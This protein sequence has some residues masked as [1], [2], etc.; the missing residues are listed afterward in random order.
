[1]NVN[2]VHFNNS[3]NCNYAWFR[4]YN[5]YDDS[6]HIR[7]YYKQFKE[8]NP[9][10]Q[11]FG[12]G[13]RFYKTIKPDT[14]YFYIITPKQLESFDLEIDRMKLRDYIVYES[15]EYAENYNYPGDPRLKVFVI[16]TPKDFV[17]QTLEQYEF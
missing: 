8:K 16:K 1:M 7:D 15:K 5:N 10:W 17:H 12:G 13:D 4:Y 11:H 2:F 6:Q 3:V 9:K 14:C